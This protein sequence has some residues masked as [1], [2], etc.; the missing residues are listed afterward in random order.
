VDRADAA[1]LTTLAVQPRTLGRTRRRLRVPGGETWQKVPFSIK[2]EVWVVTPH[3]RGVR[4]LTTPGRD[5]TASTILDVGVAE[6]ASI[7]RWG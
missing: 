7:M 4:V 1:G 3:S 2:R 5:A 6:I